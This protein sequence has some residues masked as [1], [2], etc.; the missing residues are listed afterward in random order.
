MKKI[1]III[2]LSLFATLI[3]AACGSTTTSDSQSGFPS[4][5]ATSDSQSGFPSGANAP[6]S[7]QLELLLGIFK[8]EGTENAVTTEQAAEL[9]PLWQAYK[10]LSQSDTTAQE[11]IDALVQQIKDT[12]TQK[13][14]DAISAM[15]LT[16]EDM[17]TIMQENGIT[18]GFGVGTPQAGQT[19][20]GFVP[21]QGGGGGQGGGQGFTPEQMATAQASGAQK[22]RNVNRIQPALFDALID[23]LQ[24]RA[25]P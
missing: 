20:P 11:E 1:L 10:S 9:I 6:L 5:T 24:E 4:S 23:L 14:I 21:G 3:L 13:Q 16:G 8:L 2:T 22:A 19:S 18:S 12:M 7:P 15:K 25:Q 17:F